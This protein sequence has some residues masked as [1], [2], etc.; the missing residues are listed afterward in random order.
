MGEKY[1]KQIENQYGANDVAVNQARNG[2]DF[3]FRGIKLSRGWL[4]R[5]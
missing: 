5:R 2:I 3:A 1:E 4:R